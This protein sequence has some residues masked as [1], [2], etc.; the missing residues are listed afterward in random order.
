M[1]G[2]RAAFTDFTCRWSYNLDASKRAWHMIQHRCGKRPGHP[3]GVDGCGIKEASNGTQS[4]I[5]YDSSMT[6]YNL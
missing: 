4:V 1:V 2:N 6:V 3:F 5:K